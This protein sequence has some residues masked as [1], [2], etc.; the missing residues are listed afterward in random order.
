MAEIDK[1]GLAT[2]N[3]PAKVLPI[4]AR[5]LIVSRGGRNVVAGVGIRI[6]ARPRILVILGPNG[7]GKSLLLRVLA[8]LVTP[9]SGSLSWAGSPPDRTRAPHIGFV[10]QRPVLLRRSA[11]DTVCFVLRAAGGPVAIIPARARAAI[12]QAKLAA[13]VSCPARQLSAGE[14]QRLALAAALALEPE[15]LFLDEPAS[16]L[17][18]ASALEIENRLIRA[19]DNGLCTVLVTHDLAQARRLADDIV[20]MHQGRILAR[21]PAAT[22]FAEPPCAEARAYINGE[23]VV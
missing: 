15:V 18:P 3:G 22:F 10:F 20:F 9:E 12:E 14:Q 5:G 1:T 19:R 2:T 6:D 13:H 17:D 23:I 11:L 16:N 8:G 7:A 4:I 21:A